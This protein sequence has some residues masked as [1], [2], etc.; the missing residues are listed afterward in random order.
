MLPQIS[1]DLPTVPDLLELPENQ[2]LALEQG[3][4]DTY[5]LTDLVPEDLSILLRDLRPPI[6]MSGRVQ[7]SSAIEL[8]QGTPAMPGEPSLQ[9][10]SENIVEKTSD[11][12]H[13]EGSGVR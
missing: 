11:A 8:I 10:E 12:G 13:A 6:D 2:A 1:Y 5:T 9:F 3:G 4:S 7:S